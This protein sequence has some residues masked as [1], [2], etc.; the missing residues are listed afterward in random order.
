MSRIGSDVPESSFSTL[1]PTQL[2]TG[3]LYASKMI[4]AL[5]AGG[6]VFSPEVAFRDNPN[7][8]Q[9]IKLD[10]NF[11]HSINHTNNA[12]AGQDYKVIAASDSKEDRLLCDW[13]YQI[14]EEIENFT[15]ARIL[16]AE[17]R[18]FLGQ[19]FAFVVGERKKLN[20]IGKG[21]QEY[22]VP[23]RIRHISRHRVR[24]MN[25]P[26]GTIEAL[27]FRPK[28]M[29]WDPLT[30][31]QKI[32]LLFM[33]ATD[34]EERFTY[35]NGLIDAL[36][37]C[38]IFKKSAEGQLI[39]LL[40][41]MGQGLM[42]LTIDPNYDPNRLTDLA[43]LQTAYEDALRYAKSRHIFTK[44]A[45]DTL[46]ILNPS[47]AGYDIIQGAIDRY[48]TAFLM[49]CL[50]STLS[51]TQAQHGN[52][53]QSYTHAES[54]KNH[55]RPDRQAICEMIT[56]QL[57]RRCLWV[58]NYPQLVNIGL[59]SARPPKFA[60]PEDR[61]DD[62]EK[63][64]RIL[65]SVLKKVAV[66]KSEYYELVGVSRPADDDDVIQ[67]ELS[68]IPSPVQPFL[69]VE[70]QALIQMP[71]PAKER[72]AQGET[73]EVQGESPETTEPEHFSL[74]GSDIGVS[75][76]DMPQFQGMD[77][78]AFLS[79]LKSSGAKTEECV[80][81]AYYLKPT[82]AEINEE[83]VEALIPKI[84]SGAEKKPIIISSDDYILDGHHRWAASERI[85]PKLGMNCI[86]VDL[87]MDQLL[88]K[89]K[90]FVSAKDLDPE[91]FAQQK[92]REFYENPTRSNKAS[93]MRAFE[94]ASRAKA[95][96]GVQP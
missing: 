95:L 59:G 16:M 89:A 5:R 64:V 69:P 51:V 85:D 62:Y 33:N 10:P 14:T 2:S 35:G 31:D 52:Y 58:L 44:R 29:R 1:Y 57:Y 93:A 80:I 13:Y 18:R 71:S 53:A 63:N 42:V 66:K 56:H 74:T 91:K 21:V 55:L 20:L 36:Y 12:V 61:K 78:P 82:Q 32:A 28:T 3:E 9:V 46:E 43:A 96:Q 47:S 40:E 70:D 68:N 37:Q 6:R 73:K 77:F 49:A 8:W 90:S 50:G 87:P 30:P 67:P 19:Y 7:A 27:L 79:H 45:G 22:W 15:D 84:K 11:N 4:S 65:D 72:E 39:D 41:R 48:N 83:K 34:D 75:R 88:D 81:R 26:D 24:L 86:R 76:E 25:R 23:R 92:L 60:L 54:S 38:Y 17:G 94:L